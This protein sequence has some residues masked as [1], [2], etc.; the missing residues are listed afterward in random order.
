MGYGGP[1]YRSA[2][3]SPVRLWGGFLMQPLSRLSAGG[4]IT[5][6]SSR[7][8]MRLGR[9]VKGA[10]VTVWLASAPTAVSPAP[11]TGAV[12]RQPTHPR[13]RDRSCVPSRWLHVYRVGPRSL[14]RMCK[15]PGR[16]QPVDDTARPGP[17]N[18]GVSLSSPMVTTSV[19]IAS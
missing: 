10:M 6:G 1:G 8:K 9:T 3:C 19:S 16:G 14:C 2:R 12:Y 4:T 7:I 13:W 17:A 5:L 15:A 18:P 11:S